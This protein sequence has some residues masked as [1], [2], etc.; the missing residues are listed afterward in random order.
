MIS[1]YPK[2]SES[3]ETYILDLVELRLE[4]FNRLSDEEILDLDIFPS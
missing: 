2:E 4:I 3:I 1:K